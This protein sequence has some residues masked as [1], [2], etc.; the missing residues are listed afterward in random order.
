[1]VVRQSAGAPASS[2]SSSARRSSSSVRLGMMV[3]AGWMRSVPASQVRVSP[4]RACSA[5][6]RCRQVRVGGSRPEPF[7][8]V[9][10]LVAGPPVGDLVDGVVPG[11][12]AGDVGGPVAEQPGEPAG[13]FGAERVRVP[14]DGTVDG[15]GVAGGVAGFGAEAAHRGLPLLDA[16]GEVAGDGVEA[17]L[18]GVGQG[19]RVAGVDEAQV[20]PVEGAGGLAAVGG[21]ELDGD[22]P[23]GV[24]EGGDGADVVPVG[25]ADLAADPRR[26]GRRGRCGR[27]A[28]RGR[29]RRS[30]GCRWRSAP[31]PWRRRGG[32]R[33]RR[34]GRCGRG[35]RRRRRRGRGCGRAAW[36]GS[37]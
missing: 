20:G 31:R 27:S 5:S 4:S 30:R 18:G 15:S 32:L 10:D 11:G 2:P 21:D 34:G 35:G 7:G 29:R 8:V 13:P 26:A 22:P 33:G 6:H 28:R 17:V 3:S 1:M 25:R 23:G 9:G 24:V 19:A 14:F 37:G 12:G 36:R 16:G